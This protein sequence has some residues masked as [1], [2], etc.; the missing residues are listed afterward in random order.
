MATLCE[1]AKK[2]IKVNF[3]WSKAHSGIRGNEIAHKAAREACFVET[4][5]YKKYVSINDINNNSKN[6]MLAS[7]KQRRSIYC[8]NSRNLYAIINPF[9]PVRSSHIFDYHG[10]FGDHL[11]R[12]GIIDIVYIEKSFEA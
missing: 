8:S 4:I 10:R 11:Y 7:W 5:E 6:N 9:L 2:G 3:V 12:M 1:L